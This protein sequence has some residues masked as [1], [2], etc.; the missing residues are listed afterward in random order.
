MLFP[1]NSYF[2]PKIKELIQ[3]RAGN[4]ASVSS[5]QGWMRISSSS[6]LVLES[7]PSDGDNSFSLRYGDTNKSGR[8][9]TTFS[10]TS[11]FV[12][13]DR[14]FRPSPVIESMGIDFGDGGLTRK[15]QFQIKCF[16]LK[17]AEELSKYFLEPGYTVLVEF[18]WNIEKS[19]SQKI[20]L[21]PCEIAKFNSYD[22][23]K[24]KQSASG[25]TYDGF[26]G[27]IT[28][29]GFTTSTGET[30]I[31]KVELTSIGEVAAYLQQH[32]SGGKKDDKK[33]EGGERYDNRTI[34]STAESNVGL[35][36]FMQMY[37]RLPMAKKTERVK[38]LI[39]EVDSRG[40]SFISEANFINMD[41]EIRKDLI[42]ELEDTAVET[43]QQEGGE[44]ENSTSGEASVPAGMPLVSE[45]S[46]IRL[47]LAFEILNKVAYE[48]KSVAS[49]C[50]SDVPTFPLAIEYRD[51]ICRAHPHMFSIDGSKLII[52]NSLTPDF[53]MAQALSATTVQQV[54]PILTADGKPERT[55]NL[56]QKD[57][58][59]N[60]FKF[61]Q[62]TALDAS[63]FPADAVAFAAESGQWGY[64]K[65]L[66][67]NFEF[68]IEVL[69]KSNY[70]AK[71]IYYEILNGI[72]AAS[73]SIWYFEIVQIP[74]RRSENK[75]R[76]QL[77]IAD[78]NFQGKP[79]KDGITGF[80]SSGIDCPFIDSQ[81]AFEIPA[82]MKNMIIAERTAA[83]G[84]SISVDSSPEGNLPIESG[85][86]FAS[87]PDPVVEIIANYKEALIKETQDRTT[88][89]P[90]QDP[91]NEPAEA[92][93]AE[94]AEKEAR[95]QNYE[96]FMQHATVVPTIKDRNINRD[97]AKSTFSDFFKAV[98][99]FVLTALAGVFGF[100]LSAET[101]ADPTLEQIVAVGAWQDATLFR[102]LDLNLRNSTTPN[103]ILVEIAFDFK[104]HGVSG[105]KTGDLFEIADLP[106]QYRD[107]C[108]FTVTSISHTLDQGLWTTMVGGK[109]KLK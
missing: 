107:K 27:Y 97:V 66:Y 40:I 84:N 67:V 47:E 5:L 82:A 89:D 11:V 21:S 72:S 14:G 60:S 24:E 96:L 76:Y 92:V 75:G 26:L 73:N 62:T 99:N 100:G 49:I 79:N 57:S 4:N 105:I 55:V 53:G 63:L 54:G 86:L 30:Y 16:S 36:L 68:F 93:D 80:F 102:K 39:N 58:A 25:Y 95:K 31:L 59:G 103:N 1:F 15:S 50:G 46:Y 20:N 35:A 56:E 13:G 10:G 70:V 45:N 106:A 43:T 81:F 3:S 2:N 101:T 42:G 8:I 77:E 104:I 34:E 108:A 83:E 74:S 71:D 52:P 22:H 69:E 17:Q 109:M 48:T 19:I 33:N 9:G 98:G 78:L 41:D 64:L 28:N 94:E 91:N 32:R 51:T 6:G 61:P 29:G 37:N 90:N 44:G 65:D 7:T 85:A 18:G 23:L 87:K 88:Q 12:E 38:Q